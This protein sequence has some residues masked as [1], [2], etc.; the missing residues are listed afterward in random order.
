MRSNRRFAVVV[1]LLG[2]AVCVGGTA[3][4]AARSAAPTSSAAESRPAP[5]RFA[6]LTDLAVQ[7]LQISDQV[8]AAKFGTGLPISDPAREQQELAQVRQDA[9]QLGVNPDLA[10]AFFQQQITASK[11]VQEGLF[12]LW[13]AHPE[14]APTSR[15]DLGVIRAE[16]DRLTTEI[17]QRLVVDQAS[18]TDTHDC[19]ASL[20]RARTSA[21]VA[22]GL[23]HLH[24]RALSTALSSVCEGFTG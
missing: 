9:L 15:P 19:R 14:L 8:A 11:I 16:L 20:A 4:A 5:G 18:M 23:D 17:M 13:T 1:S 24:R 3:Q 7:R 2:A 21:A 12:D 10:V 22:D 6:A